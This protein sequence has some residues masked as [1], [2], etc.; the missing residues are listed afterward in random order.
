[1]MKLISNY[2]DMMI[3]YVELKAEQRVSR[4]AADTYDNILGQ[5][6]T[7]HTTTSLAELISL[8]VPGDARSSLLPLTDKVEQM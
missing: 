3:S 6:K 4:H 7:Q 2:P 5:S 8:A 1:M